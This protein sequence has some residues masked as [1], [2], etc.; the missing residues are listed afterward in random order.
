M[1][2]GFEAVKIAKLRP[3]WE[4]LLLDRLMHCV[5]CEPA[6]RGG[7]FYDLLLENGEDVARLEVDANTKVLAKAPN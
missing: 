6:E 3:E 4:V 2:D 7:D 5:M 1:L